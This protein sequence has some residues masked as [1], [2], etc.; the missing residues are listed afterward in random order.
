MPAPDVSVAV[1][2]HS[3]APFLARWPYNIHLS[4]SQTRIRFW[5]SPPPPGGG[6]CNLANETRFTRFC[7]YVYNERTPIYRHRTELTVTL[8][9]TVSQL[10]SQ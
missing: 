4:V 10:V 3:I 6:L 1:Q 9:L 7:I 2:G 8:Q 5:V